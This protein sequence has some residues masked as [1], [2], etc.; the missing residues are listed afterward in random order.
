MNIEPTESANNAAGAMPALKCAIAEAQAMIDAEIR[1]GNVVKENWWRGK[2]AGLR[3]AKAMLY[4]AIG[5]THA[6]S[7]NGPAGTIS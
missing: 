1:G 2:L 3:M 7:F 4:E 5:G 6:D